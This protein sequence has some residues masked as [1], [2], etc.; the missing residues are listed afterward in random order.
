MLACD[1][2]TMSSSSHRYRDRKPPR[3]FAL[4]AWTMLLVVLL[5]AVPTE[6][7]ARTRL[8]GSAFDPTTVSVALSPKQPKAKASAQSPERRRLPVSASGQPS[9]LIA[10]A[11]AAAVVFVPPAD[12]GPSPFVRSAPDPARRSLT[13]AHGPRAPPQA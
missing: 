7:Q 10:I 6:G 12:A 5:S 3:A 8:I 4:W 2:R 11:P 9:P 1:N 13:K